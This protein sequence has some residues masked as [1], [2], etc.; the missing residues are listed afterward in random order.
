[1]S[2]KEIRGEEEKRTDLPSEFISKTD[3]SVYDRHEVCIDD[4]RQLNVERLRL[5]AHLKK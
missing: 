3:F 4:P 2:G 5:L 1:M